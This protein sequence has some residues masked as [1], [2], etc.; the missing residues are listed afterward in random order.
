MDKI[1]KYQSILQLEM[2]EQAK[3]SLY[4]A[5][6]VHRHLIINEDKSDFLLLSIGWEDSAYRHNVIH[7]IQLRG[8]KVWILKNNTNIEID[9]FLI[10][11]G[12]QKEDIEVGWIPDYLR[13]LET[14]S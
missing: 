8:N 5:P 4:N 6:N 9:E 14:L 10:E 2:E 13:E 11:K 1:E 7:H 3:K 12:I